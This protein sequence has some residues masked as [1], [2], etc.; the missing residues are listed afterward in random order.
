MDTLTYSEAHEL[1][2]AAA[3]MGALSHLA[4]HWDIAGDILT[5][6]ALHAFVDECVAA[7]LEAGWDSRSGRNPPQADEDSDT[8]LTALDMGAL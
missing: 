1:V 7:I 6:D 5:A 8:G 3:Q 2:D 4:A